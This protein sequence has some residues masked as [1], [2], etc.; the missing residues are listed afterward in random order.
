MEINFFSNDIYKN[1][2]YSVTHLRVLSFE[3]YKIVLLY[4]IIFI[5]SG[6]CQ[7]FPFSFFFEINFNFYIIT[8][9]YIFSLII[10]IIFYILFKLNTGQYSYL[11]IIINLILKPSLRKILSISISYYSIYLIIKNTKVLMPRLNSDYIK[12]IYDIEPSYIDEDEEN[13]YIR[14][15]I[16]KPT[17]YENFDYIYTIFTTLFLLFNYIFIIQRFNLWPKLCLGHIDNLKKNIL[18]IISNIGIIGFPSFLFIYIMIL[19]YYHTLRIIDISLNYLSLLIFV[20][21]LLYI[22][23][24]I[25]TNFICPKI[26]YVTN[27]TITKGQVIRKE[28]NLI[29]EDTFYIIHHFKHLCFFY[30]YPHD[31]K[32]NTKL[33]SFENFKIIQQKIL[34]YI[35]SLKRK[36]SIFLYQKRYYTLNNNMNLFEKIKNFTGK[37]MD[38]LDFSGNQILENETNLEIIKLV[39]ELIG[40]I[41]LFIFDA[42]IMK[43]NEEKYEIYSDILP[44]FI[45]RLIEI[46]KILIGLIQNRKISEQLNIYLYKLIIIINNYFNLIKIR[47]NKGQFINFNSERIKGM[48][49]NLN[50]NI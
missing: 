10:D 24:D 35:N 3:I 31:I 38:Y 19:L 11:E 42:K 33:L 7:Y 40:N 43:S 30:A 34:F 20:Y 18:F 25:I 45:E 39:I 36:Y 5:L 21:N 48:K 37:I 49:I 2:I 4:I 26:N 29:E 41:I 15:G 22:S 12:D 27:E 44:F 14:R 28:I 6:I 46:D 8:K 9:I 16:S 32:L 1:K 50:N 47:Q 13:Y 17:I 23:T